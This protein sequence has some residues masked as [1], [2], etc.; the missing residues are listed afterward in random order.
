MIKR[1]SS[2]QESAARVNGFLRTLSSLPGQIKQGMRLHRLYPPGNT[3][4]RMAVA[5]YFFQKDNKD[6]RSVN[7]ALRAVIWQ[8][9]QRDAVYQ[10]SVAGACDK[11]EEFGNTLELWRQLIVQFSTKIEVTIFIILDG[12]DEAK[13]ETGD[14]LIQILREVSLFAAEKRPL[15]LRLLITGRPMSFLE[16]NKTPNIAMST[17]QLG[18]RNTEDILKFVELRLDTMEIFKKSDQPDIQELKERIRT[19]LTHGAQGDFFKLNYMLTEISKKRRRKEIE[20]VLE[21]ADEDRQ[22]TIAREI[23]RLR[24]ALGDEDIEDLNEVLIWV[25]GA[26]KYSALLEV[27][28]YQTLAVT[29]QSIIEYF[30]AKAQQAAEDKAT[31]TALHE[32]EIAI[33]KR[34]L[35]NFCDD[36]LFNKFG[37]EEFFQ[38]KLSHRNTSIHADLDNMDLHIL[39]SLLKAICGELRSEVFTLIEAPLALNLLNYSRRKNMLTGGGR[40]TACGCGLGLTVEQREWVNGLN[41]SSRPNDDL[42]KPIAKIMAKRWLQVCGLWFVE[43]IYWWLLGCVTKVKERTGE[44]ERVTSDVSPTLEQILEV[45]KWA[46]KELGVTEQD[47]LWTVRMAI[48]FRHYGFYQQ[49]IERSTISKNLDS[50]SNWRAPFCLAQTHALQGRYKMALET[51]EEV[52]AMFR[53]NGDIME[54]WCAAFYSDILYYLREWNVELQE[55]EAAN[56]HNPD[57]YEPIL[58]IILILEAQEKYGEIIEYSKLYH[59]T[60]TKAGRAAGQLEAVKETYQVAIEAAKS[61][62]T[63]LTTLTALRYWYPLFLYYDYP[64]HNAHEEAITIWEQNIASIPRISNELISN[65]RWSTVAKLA[66]SYIQEAREAEGNKAIRSHIKL[67]LDILDDNDES[68]DWQEFKRLCICLSH[69]ENDVNTLAAWSLLGP[70]ID[71]EAT[72]DCQEIGEETF[73][74]AGGSESE[75]AAAEEDESSEV[76]SQ[77]DAGDE[78][79]GED[80]QSANVS[81][82]SPSPSENGYGGGLDGHLA[83]I[84]DGGCGH[85]WS[86][87]DDVYPCKDFIDVQFDTA[88][89]EKLT[90]GTLGQKVCNK[91]H[92]ILH[93]PRWG[94][95]EA[96]SVP[97]SHV[98][99]GGET[100]TIPDWLSTIRKKYGFD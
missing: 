59:E 55:Y 83:F 72:S 47:S 31:H 74:E 63:R 3:E 4:D 12:I 56:A 77:T 27:S 71:R 28:E 50:S 23:E 89:Y 57:S 14:P 37:F 82:T 5:Y 36:E 35:R 60:I 1:N 16:I 15:S 6:E 69:I 91:N 81:E 29:S 10:K 80:G 22:A 75:A 11:P 97:G 42:L 95:E 76:L 7:K 43:D 41:S 73:S 66:T 79:E 99:V 13:A 8:L 25:I 98:R 34:F 87:A 33:V 53:K 68:N 92:D 46:M 19:E 94:F 24:Q 9:T 49:A 51:L 17:I 96:A 64:H 20:E 67:A 48:T 85:E 90:A 39:L 38:E 32:S 84:C 44:G 45:E 30:R 52:I 93:V 78:E 26:M 18:T 65:V 58:R 40:K 88:C 62:E 21:H 54:E 86:Y 70:T 2:E 61:G 100:I